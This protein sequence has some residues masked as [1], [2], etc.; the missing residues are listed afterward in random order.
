M[1]IAKGSAISC[2]WTQIKYKDHIQDADVKE[3]FEKAGITCESDLYTPEN[4]AKATIILL[5]VLAK[6]IKQNEKAQNG[7]EAARNSIVTVDGWSKVNGEVK[8]TYDTQSWINEIT[9]EDILCYYWNGKGR[10]VVNGTMQP[11]A[12]EYTRNIRKYL[13]KLLEC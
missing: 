9:E 7:A 6:R 3:A 2:G 13:K 12:N 4:S 5:N 10:Q 8:K 1:K 11:E